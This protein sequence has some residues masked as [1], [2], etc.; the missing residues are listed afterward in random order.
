LLGVTDPFVVEN[1]SA[2]IVPPN[3]VGA[4]ESFIEDISGNRIIVLGDAIDRIQTVLDEIRSQTALKFNTFFD[5]SVQELSTITGLTIEAA[6][7]ARRRE[8]SCPIITPFSSQDFESLRSVCEEHGLKCEIGGRFIGV[9]GE[10]T[11]KGHAVSLLTKLYRREGNDIVTVGVGDSANDLP[12]F[13]VVDQPYLVQR[14]NGRWF[15]IDVPRM[16]RVDQIGPL[17]FTA[18]V[19]I[20]L[21]QWG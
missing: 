20:I 9:I 18:V 3:S 8:Y 10:N 4:G 19:D 21:R 7:N 17:G 5:V 11:D 6:E 16:Q 1:G 13:Q 15:E 2:I 12:M 14:P